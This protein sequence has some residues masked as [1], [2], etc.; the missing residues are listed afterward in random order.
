MSDIILRQRTTAVA[1]NTGLNNKIDMKI[2]ICMAYTNRME[3][4]KRTLRAFG[5]SKENFSVAIANDGHEKLSISD[6][7]AIGKYIEILDNDGIKEKTWHDPAVPVNKALSVAI[8]DLRS[9]VIILCNPE[10]MPVGDIVSDCTTLK[11]SEY[12]VYGCLSLDKE[13]SDNIDNIDLVG[14][15]GSIERG[16]GK[17]FDLAWYQHSIYR[18]V[19]YEFCAAIN[20]SDMRRLNG[21][22]ERLAFG[23]GYS[24]N[25][26]LHRI[27]LMGMNVTMVDDPFVAHQWHAKVN[28]TPQRSD[29]VNANRII[30]NQL[31]STITK[32]KALRLITKDIL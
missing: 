29:L 17:D 27:K 3:Q 26:L 7:P 22:D 6:L 24:D 20:A 1:E 18:P 30:F 5:K 25:Y 10:C 2:T 32:P 21:Y 16:A 14:L 8:N 11:P 12:R 13:T 15:S 4:L 23:W 28:D 31:I 9:D 19:C